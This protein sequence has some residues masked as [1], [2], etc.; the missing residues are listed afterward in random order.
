[1]S[2]HR[3]AHACHTEDSISTRRGLKQTS[4]A[5]TG[6]HIYRAASTR[7]QEHKRKIQTEKHTHI[8]IHTYTHTHTDTHRGGGTE[9]IGRGCNRCM[10][11]R[12]NRARPG[13]ARTER[14]HSEHH[15]SSAR[16]TKG[17]VCMC[18]PWTA[19]N[20]KQQTDRQTDTQ[21]A[22]SRQQT[23]RRTSLA[24][25]KAGTVVSVSPQVT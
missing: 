23:D 21:T 5:H 7:A 10:W 4:S 11:H 13:R 15:K 22:D 25:I 18:K 3:G 12:A 6:E 2:T 14:P 19:A 9:G 8:Q 24:A 16:E 17:R 1:M 20:S